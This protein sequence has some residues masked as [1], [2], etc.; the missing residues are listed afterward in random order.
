MPI[1][2]SLNTIED[3]LAQKRIAMIGVSRNPKEFSAVLFQE[4][5]KRG[6]D[7]VP[8]NPKASEVL[9]LHCFARVQD[10]QP[11]VDGALLMTS[12][13]VTDSVVLDCAA[14]GIR[15]VWLYSA[16][17]KGAV[18]TSAVELCQENGIEVV[19]GQCPFMFLPHA[20]GVHR[21]HGFIR[22]VTGRFPKHEHAA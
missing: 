13:L 5:Q 17:N 14:A 8:V 21:F 6:Y 3:F 15:R 4:L 9:G 7:M 16:G 1:A 10:I 22:K 12:A 18:T 2:V 19:P 11:P 20:G